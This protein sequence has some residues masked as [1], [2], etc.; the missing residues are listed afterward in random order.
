MAVAG[1]MLA[2]VCLRLGW[3]DGLDYLAAHHVTVSASWGILWVSLGTAG[4]YDSRRLDG[5]GRTL[6]S[7]GIAV[8]GG[9]LLATALL[10]ATSSW[11]TARGILLVFAVLALLAVLVMRLVHRLMGKLSFMTSRCL[12]LGTDGEA[13][14]VIDLIHRHPDAGLH[15]VGMVQ[16][17]EKQG[18]GGTRIE[19]YPVLGTDA[20]LK[21]V[22]DSHRIDKL[23]VAPPGEPKAAFLQRLR[24]F[25][26]RGVAL[27]DY[28]SLHEELTQEISV[29]HID[30]EWLFAAAMNNSR[31]YIRWFKRAF[32]MAGS[33]GAL[34]LAAPLATVVAL[35]VKL[36]SPGPV[37]FR[38]DRL[39]RDGVTFTILKFRTM[40]VD[41]ES[42]TGPVW[43]MAD[44]SRITRVGRWL[45]KLRIDELPQLINVLRG[46]MSLIGPRP[47]RQVFVKQLAEQIPFYAER[48]M[49]HPGIT[50]W[51]Q[52]MQSYAA[53]VEQSR[54]KLQADLYYIKHMSF[55]TDVY[56]LFKTVKV[57]LSGRERSWPVEAPARVTV[58]ESPRLIKPEPN[59]SGQ[60]SAAARRLASGLRARP[61][62]HPA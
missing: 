8:L 38:Q 59:A 54:R 27:A 48:L 21:Q 37:F 58:I 50:G 43:A 55:L 39:G 15:V 44:D 40:I 17:G 4:F 30:D 26:Y 12:V 7:A 57:V 18:I 60:L 24:S 31:P 9:T 45:R 47:E 22:V 34:V 16:Y 3:R 61:R 25:R 5:L 29:E 14:K 42:R 13:Q 52:V 11:H 46:E 23:I 35:L 49:V 2:A 6:A 10:W 32:D 20:S 53:S 19:N 56:V 36:D 51:A 41:A 1:A 33:V 62:R 28:V